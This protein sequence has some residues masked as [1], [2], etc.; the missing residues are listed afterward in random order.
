M[1]T[2]TKLL[3]L[4]TL[5]LLLIGTITIINVTINFKEFSTNSAVNKAK[6]TA[7]IVKDGLTAHMVNGIMDKRQYFLNKISTNKEINALWIVRS[8]NVIKQYGKGLNDETPRDTIDKEVLKNGKLIK[9]IEEQQGKVLLRVTIPYTATSRGNPNC[10]SCHNVQDG[11][12][13][14]AISME[15]DITSTKHESIR[16]I[17]KIMAITVVFIVLILLLINYYISPYMRLFSNMQ[18][19]IAKAFKGDFSHKFETS[20]DGDAQE[21][22][23]QLNILF[24]KINETFGHI[25]EDLGTF[26]PNGNLCSSD[27][28]YEAKTIIHEL[29]DIY[30]FKKTIEL[31][32]T[33]DIVY[34]RIT[35]ILQHKYNLQHFALYEVDALTNTRQLLFIT[36][37]KE[38]ICMPEA[39]NDAKLCRAYRTESDV[40]SCEFENLCQASRRDDIH[41]ICIPFNINQENSIVL[42]ISSKTKDEID[43]IATLITQIKHYLEAA[44][45][46]IESN[47]LMEKLRDSSLKDA[48]TG[49]YNRRFLEEFIDKVMSQS[50][51]EEISYSILMLDVDHFKMVNDTYGHDVGDQVISQIGRVLREN[52]READLAIRYGG[53]EF[54]V[55]LHNATHEGTLEVATKIHKT[56][57]ELHFEVGHGDVIQKTLSIGISKFPDDGDT[58]WKCIKY[59]DTALYVAKTTGRNKIVEYKKEMS[60]DENIR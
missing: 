30:K 3:F 59:A 57:S 32:R 43:H 19:G 1:K 42:S 9:T 36:E 46:V 13:L 28:L 20:V 56:F 6:A 34:S 55:M 7:E 39:D 26:I 17:V 29:S 4:V 8:Q 49:L 15:F 35:D 25:K 2:K 58:I 60:E 50:Q 11:T 33:K 27:P 38:S 14:G 40:V 37:Q 10:L 48:M 16:T 52:I 53:E 51:R 44:K 22:V 54:I 12:I 24:A 45:P 41:Y 47:L 18:E 23:S 21:I 31:D 5:L